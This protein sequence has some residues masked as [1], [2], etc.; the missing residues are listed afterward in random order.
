MQVHRSR[1]VCSTHVR[2][3]A[4]IRS[5][6]RPLR[7]SLLPARQRSR[8]PGLVSV[9]KL[10]AVPGFGLRNIFVLWY[11]SS[12][13][14]RMAT[15]RPATLPGAVIEPVATRLESLPCLMRFRP[16]EAHPQARP[17]STAW[18][19]EVPR[20]SL[21]SRAHRPEPATARIAARPAAAISGSVHRVVWE[22]LLLQRFLR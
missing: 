12:I 1:N 3:A 20:T 9:Y 18:P 6:E 13:C 5:A 15:A 2:S 22:T 21:F 17:A 11:E 7:L 8:P 16:L 10:P 14:I 4:G 19:H